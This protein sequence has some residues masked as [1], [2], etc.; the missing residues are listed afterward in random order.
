MNKWSEFSEICSRKKIWYSI[1]LQWTIDGTLLPL[2]L[3]LSLSLF[4][5]VFL[6]YI[7]CLFLFVFWVVVDA[8]ESKAITLTWRIPTYPMLSDSTQ[9]S[10]YGFWH[11]WKSTR[12]KDESNTGREAWPQIW[13][14][15][16]WLASI[17]KAFTFY[18]G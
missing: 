5:S 15:A 11:Q 4:F 18:L 12:N 13:S 8:V 6:L 16:S 10:S 1:T 2:F 9:C 3:S 17:L 7:F 14:F